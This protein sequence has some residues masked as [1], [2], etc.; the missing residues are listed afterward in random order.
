VTIPN[1]LINDTLAGNGVHSPRFSRRVTGI[2]GRQSLRPDRAGTRARHTAWHGL[3][4]VAALAW[5]GQL[6]LGGGD[7]K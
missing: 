5:A 3:D 1:D 6:G 2:P 4:I 7:A